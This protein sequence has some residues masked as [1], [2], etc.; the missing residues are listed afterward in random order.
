MLFFTEKCKYIHHRYIVLL[1]ALSLKEGCAEQCSLDATCINVP[2]PK[3]RGR[4]CGTYTPPFSYGG[5]F[6]KWQIF[7]LVRVATL[8]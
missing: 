6:I 8:L 7:T 2:P 3:G 5:K 4:F 1:L